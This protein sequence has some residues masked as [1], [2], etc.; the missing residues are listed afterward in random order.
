MPTGRQQQRSR[1]KAGEQNHSESVFGEGLV[2]HLV[3]GADTAEGDLRIDRMHGC[4]D[5]LAHGSGIV[6]GAHADREVRR[7][8]LGEWDINL[9]ASLAEISV[10]DVVKDPDNLPLN[11]RAKLRA[12][13]E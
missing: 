12:V 4:G 2:L 13:R 3:H 11:R 1:C 7:Q 8:R 6:G 5:G 9:R 10:H